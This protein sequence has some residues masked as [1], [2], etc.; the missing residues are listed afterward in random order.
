MGFLQKPAPAAPGS[1]HW[2]PFPE[3]A[4]SIWARCCDAMKVQRLPILFSQACW[5]RDDTRFCAGIAPCM[6]DMMIDT[7]CRNALNAVC[8]GSLS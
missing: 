6:L 7:L 3:T 2:L 4:I 1:F 5:G 8:E